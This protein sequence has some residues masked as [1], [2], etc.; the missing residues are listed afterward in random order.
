MTV[1]VVGD[2]EGVESVAAGAG[3]LN[4]ASGEAEVDAAAVVADLT[5]I[6]GGTAELQP[7][8]R[9]PATAR[10]RRSPPGLA[11]LS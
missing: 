6:A 4:A 9:G 7:L 5:R 11:E 2:V 8:M 10:L 3:A 1:L